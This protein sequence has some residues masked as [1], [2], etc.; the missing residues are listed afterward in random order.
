MILG[1][2]C[3]LTPCLCRA[4]S[5]D[6]LVEAIDSLNLTSTSGEDPVRNFFRTRVS[7]SSA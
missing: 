3:D 6:I 4:T 1:V 5:E 2:R 7:T